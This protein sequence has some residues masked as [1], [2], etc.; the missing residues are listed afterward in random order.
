MR[1]GPCC[2]LALAVYVCQAE[3]LGIFDGCTEEHPR[4]IALALADLVVLVERHDGDARH[5]VHARWPAAK[6]AAFVE[7]DMPASLEQRCG[8]LSRHGSRVA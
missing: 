4:G 1:N 8:L 3:D 6:E 5:V 7:Q 2:A